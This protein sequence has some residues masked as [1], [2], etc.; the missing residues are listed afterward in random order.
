MW[1]WPLKLLI[2]ITLSGCQPGPDSVLDDYLSRLERVLKQPR[3][4]SSLPSPQRPARH[5]FE[6]DDS[7]NV[8]L[9]A[10]LSLKP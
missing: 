10:P 7:L 4:E 5:P 1:Q 6:P 9:L 3:P 2:L 8:S